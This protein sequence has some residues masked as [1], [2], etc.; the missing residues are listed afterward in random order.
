L[1]A[2][3]ACLGAQ[4]VLYAPSNS[5]LSRREDSVDDW[6]W[7]HVLWLGLGQK[8]RKNEWNPRTS[9]VPPSGK[10]MLDY[11]RGKRVGLLAYVYPVLPFSQNPEWLVP[12]R[13]DPKRQ[14]AS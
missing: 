6:S 11:A 3:V 14:G 5:A 13:S 8:I 12:T 10:E 4:Y 2:G 1:I 9:P 7:E